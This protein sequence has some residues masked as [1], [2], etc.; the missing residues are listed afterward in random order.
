MSVSLRFTMRRDFSRSIKENCVDSW[1]RGC[2][3][4][5][6]TRICALYRLHRCASA[7]PSG[8]CAF[9]DEVWGVGYMISA[10]FTVPTGTKPTVVLTL[11]LVAHSYHPMNYRTDIKTCILGALWCKHREIRIIPSHAYRQTDYLL[12]KW[13]CDLSYHSDKCLYTCRFWPP[14]NPYIGYLHLRNL[15]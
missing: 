11:G 4:I 6:Q 5:S 13:T 3:I 14:G 7:A 9:V 10:W 15:M 1:E 12:C 2:V 8:G